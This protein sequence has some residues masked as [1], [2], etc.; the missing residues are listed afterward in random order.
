VVKT[1]AQPGKGAPF[2]ETVTAVPTD[3]AGGTSSRG[4]LQRDTPRGEDRVAMQIRSRRALVVAYGM[5][6]SFVSIDWAVVHYLQ[7]GRWWYFLAIRLAI[8]AVVAPVLL[9]MHKTPPLTERGLALCD[10]TAYSVSAIGIALM[11]IEFRGI[12]SPYMPGVCL[13]LLSRSVTAQDPWKRG[14]AL[15]G[16]PVGLFFFVLLGSAIF[17]PRIAAQLRDP[18]A[19]MTMV[20]GASYV[21]GTYL[22]LVVGG[23]VVWALR[24]QVFEARSLGRYRLKRRLA[25]GGMGDVWVAYHAGLKRDVAVKILRPEQQERSASA[26]ARFEREV[27]ATAELVHPNTVRVFDYGSTED[28]V[29]Y[30]VMELLTGETLAEHVYRLG[31]LAP[32]RAVHIVG[33]A[34][35]A[36]AEAHERGIVHRDVKPENLFLTSLGGEH[37]FVKVL[38]F[39]IAKVQS[40]DGTMTGTGSVLGTP[41]YISPEVAMGRDAD[42]RSDVYG[43][44]AVLYFL[45]CGRPPFEADSPSAL[46]F[47]HVH[48]PVARPSHMLGRQL[49]TDVESVVM[50]CLEKDPGMRYATAVELAQALSSCTLAGTWTFNNAT[51]VARQSSRPPPASGFHETLPPM[52]SPGVPQEWAGLANETHHSS[53]CVGPPDVQEDALPR[54]VS[55][56]PR[57]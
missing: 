33:Q 52:C 1:C 44:G 29:W 11:C 9:R 38:D 51:H 43:L 23:H 35:R 27:R 26:H 4:Y 3:R 50:R 49:P 10:V 46:I 55:G 54:R 19:L 57:A 30:Y 21:I 7:A 56:D 14:L 24:R 22:F 15:T 18:A 41:A 32:A 16:I 42:A 20:L 36:L 48:E 6:A 13:V 47:A 40:P 17:S 28:G 34:A 31:A 53:G 12:T 37:D 8:L 39:G 45:L 5:W 2:E 25:A